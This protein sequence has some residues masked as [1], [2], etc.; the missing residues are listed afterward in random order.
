MANVI[1]LQWL[2]RI[3]ND[4]LIYQKLT[5]AWTSSIMINIKFTRLVEEL[6]QNIRQATDTDSVLLSFK[7]D[8]EVDRLLKAH[9]FTVNTTFLNATQRFDLYS[10]RSL[11][12][13]FLSWIVWADSNQGRWVESK[14][15]NIFVIFFDNG[16]RQ[17][18]WHFSFQTT[19]AVI[20]D[21]F[22]KKLKKEIFQRCDRIKC[23]LGSAFHFSSAL[24]FDI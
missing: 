7:T 10:S 18:P 19:A 4:R 5:R 2:W 22:S 16:K 11:G 6:R 20:V 1:L 17:T 21:I 23:S 3:S 15:G 9:C 14:E 8:I 24:N 12:L 13:K